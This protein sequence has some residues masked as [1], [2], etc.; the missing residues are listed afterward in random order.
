[1]PVQYP[2]LGIPVDSVAAQALVDVWFMFGL[3][4]AVIGA[5]L[6]YFSR[7]PLR[8]TAVMRTVLG[9]ELVRGIV[10][11][12]YLIGRGYDP[13][14]YLIWILVHLVILVI[15]VVV[16]RRASSRGRGVREAHDARR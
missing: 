12:L 2:D 9:L 15:G 5:A 13:V 7:D 6:V 1:M 3:E 4:V 8:H 10:D 16:T 14:P 11:D